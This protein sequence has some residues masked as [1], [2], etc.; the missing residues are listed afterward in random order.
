MVTYLRF[1]PDFPTRLLGTVPVRLLF[2]KKL[3]RTNTTEIKWMKG[4][5]L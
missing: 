4:H 1:S 3:P 5:N 2:C